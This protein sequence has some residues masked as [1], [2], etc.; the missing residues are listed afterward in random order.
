MLKNIFLGSIYG[1]C[2]CAIVEVHALFHLKHHYFPFLDV[3]WSRF[4]ILA[5]K[6]NF[7]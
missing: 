7:I 6:I 3:Y 2:N 5:K 4:D 1:R